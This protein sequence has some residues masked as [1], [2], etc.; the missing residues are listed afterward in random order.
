MKC[1]QQ[2]IHF[3]SF[4]YLA[5]PNCSDINKV[6]EIL[7]TKLKS[8]F[9]IF[10]KLSTHFYIIYHRLYSCLVQVDGDTDLPDVQEEFNKLILNEVDRLRKLNGLIVPEQSLPNGDY[11]AM[12]QDIEAEEAR[13]MNDNDDGGINTISKTVAAYSNNNN[14][15][16]NIR[17]VTARE[18]PSRDSIRDMYA[19]V[20][21]YRLD[22][23]M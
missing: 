12:L 3:C 14:N 4:L 16:N 5:F 6:K 15:M 19:Q 20:E 1:R 22:S 9:F 17:G 23:N 7:Q 13:D 11:E 8:D 2:V 10:P 21:T 18:R